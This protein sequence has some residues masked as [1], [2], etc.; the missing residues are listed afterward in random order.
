[1]NNLANIFV[2]I[3]S[4]DE[5]F[6]NSLVENYNNYLRD[7]EN[8]FYRMLESIGI[9]YNEHFVKIFLLSTEDDC[10]LEQ[11]LLY[12]YDSLYEIVNRHKSKFGF[13]QVLLILHQNIKANLVIKKIIENILS[14]HIDKHLALLQTQE[15]PQY[16]KYLSA[17]K[18][19]SAEVSQLFD[20]VSFTPE[21]ENLVF[22]LYSYKSITLFSSNGDSIAMFVRLARIACNLQIENFD[23]KLSQCIEELA[24]QLE[25]RLDRILSGTKQLDTIQDVAASLREIKIDIEQ[26]LIISKSMDFSIMR[27]FENKFMV[28]Q[29]FIENKL[30][31]ISN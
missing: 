1:M 23:K 12:Y 6:Y 29:R 8:D 11:K 28:T 22:N 18:D 25:K 14:K 5:A 19:N 15:S 2:D 27:S 13:I 21:L 16:L 17:I 10:F 24:Y 26:A 4:I 31:T 20:I 3:F 7:T 30:F 9:N